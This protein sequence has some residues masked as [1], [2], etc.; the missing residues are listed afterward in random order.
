MSL[1]PNESYSFPE[2][3]E[4]TVRGSKKP[5]EKVS[6]PPATGPRPLNEPAPEPPAVRPEL[7]RQLQAAPPQAKP[8]KQ[9]SVRRIPPPIIR[10]KP[11]SIAPVPSVVRREPARNNIPAVVHLKRKVRYNAHLVAPERSPESKAAVPPASLING[12]PKQ[13][14][15]LPQTPGPI[16]HPVAI[17]TPRPAATRVPASSPRPNVPVAPVPAASAPAIPAEEQIEFELSDVAPSYPRRWS[18]KRVRFLVCEGI[19][20]AALMLFAI[21]GLLRTFSGRSAGLYINI[22]TIAAAVAAT[23]IPILFFAIGPTLPRDDR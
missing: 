9:K 20:I 11:R 13:K 19:A 18:R 3:F 23:L 10:E 1:I 14:P 12:A 17:P 5:E 22:L 2:D 16:Q 4:W 7:T 8:E 21:L 6:L 15:Q